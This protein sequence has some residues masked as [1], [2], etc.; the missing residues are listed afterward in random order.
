MPYNVIGVW[1]F[2]FIFAFLHA[3]VLQSDVK[4]KTKKFS[5]Y[6]DLLPHLPKFHYSNHKITKAQGNEIGNFLPP[7]IKQTLHS[8]VEFETHQFLPMQKWN[9]WWNPLYLILESEFGL[10]QA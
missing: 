9:R 2:F 8:D 5:V 4:S 7:C 3:S 6:L 1:D 10:I